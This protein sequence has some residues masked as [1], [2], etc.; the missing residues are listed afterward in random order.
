MNEKTRV[1][2][3]I[4]GSISNNDNVSEIDITIFEKMSWAT[5]DFLI[6]SR[7]QYPS[8]RISK[9]SIAIVDGEHSESRLH[10]PTTVQSYALE[11]AGTVE[12]VGAN[13]TVNVIDN[14]LHVYAD[15]DANIED[16]L[17]AVAR[18]AEPELDTGAT[19]LERMQH[20]TWPSESE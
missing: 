7:D 6:G 8:G 13:I 10:A 11:Q 5:I 20:A 12:S 19:R 17:H 2:N 15:E 3:R 4:Q 9:S 1:V 18:I 14:V 16:V